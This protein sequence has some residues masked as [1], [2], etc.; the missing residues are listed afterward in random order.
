M[1]L[2]RLPLAPHRVH[3]KVA[4]N[5]LVGFWWSYFPATFS[6]DKSLFDYWGDDVGDLC[7]LWKFLRPG[8]TFLDVGAYHGIYAI[9][10]AKKLGPKGHVVAFEPSPRDR[11]RLELHLW[12]NGIKTVKVEPYAVTAQKGR[13]SLLVVVDGYT[14]MNSLRRPAI[15]HPVKQV[16]VETTSL[17]EYFT[18]SHVEL[19]DLVK[20]DAEVGELDIFRGALICL[21]P[22]RICEVLDK[23]TAPWDYPAREIVGQLKSYDY[24]WFEILGNGYLLPH[25]PRK[26]YPDG[27]NYLAAPREKKDRLLSLVSS[28]SSAHSPSSLLT[29]F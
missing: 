24:E 14:N 8:M 29:R 27:K 5:E 3:L 17:D 1:W 4:T 2:A 7:F 20:I 25:H 6:S 16:E 23:V 9:I 13:A 11:H 28:E 19:V 21:R 18:S 22:L 26:Q 15:D 10:A 12:C